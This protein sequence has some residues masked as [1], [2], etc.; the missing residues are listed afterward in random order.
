[1]K[2]RSL[3]R[4]GVL[5]GAV[6]GA[7][8]ATVFPAP[9]ISQGRIQW[10]MVTTWPKNFPGH[11]TGAQ[12]IADRIG[13][14]TDGRLE[15]ELYGAGDLVPAFESFDAVRD[16]VAE[17]CHSAA[18]YWVAK[19]KSTPFFCAVPGGLTQQEHMAWIHYGGGQAL[20]DELYADFGLKGF[21]AGSTGVQMGGWFRK[22]INS[23][24]DFKGLKM[25]IPGLGGEVVEHLGATAVNLPGGEI[26]SAL[27]LGLIDAAEW[28]GPWSD[29]LFGFHKVASFYYGPGFHEPNSALELIVS[30]GK[31]DSLPRDIQGAIESAAM[32]EDGKI[33]SEFTAANSRAQRLLVEKY[34]VRIGSFSDDIIKAAYEASEDLVR[35]TATEGDLA[36]RIFDSW[37]NFRKDAIERAPYAEQGFMNARARG[38]S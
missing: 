26:M 36:R 20:W 18:Y 5:K 28:V 37:W 17:M 25:R 35:K 23:L 24:D 13:V 32:V 12:R 33:L 6:A 9:A 27:E 38:A 2:R 1:M 4:R 29:L 3:S 11:G 14:L 8:A 19:H 22:E 30:K 16:G 34:G 31:F 10:K 15:V 21:L 7:A